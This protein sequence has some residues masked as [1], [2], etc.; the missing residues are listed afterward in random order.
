MTPRKNK[1]YAPKMFELVEV[2]WDDATMDFDYDGPAEASPGG[3]CK[4]HSVGYFV[5]RDATKYVIAS[6]RE[7]NN[8][9]VRLLLNIPRKMMVGIKSLEPP[10]EADGEHIPG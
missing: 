7:S 8:D 3:L 2:V 10:K 6:T 4:L 5:S 1:L 9:S